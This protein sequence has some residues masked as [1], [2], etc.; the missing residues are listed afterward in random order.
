MEQYLWSH[1]QDNQEDR[2]RRNTIKSMYRR[3]EQR[4]AAAREASSRQALD[5]VPP[6]LT[7]TAVHVS[8]EPELGCL[9]QARPVCVGAV[10]HDALQVGSRSLSVEPAFVAPASLGVSQGEA[11]RGCSGGIMDHE[12]SIGTAIQLPRDFAIGQVYVAYE[13]PKP[14]PEPE[15]EP[16]P[17]E[18]EPEPTPE[19]G[20]EPNNGQTPASEPD[21]TP[22]G[23]GE[24]VPTS[25]AGGVPGN[26]YDGTLR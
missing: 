15:P 4:L 21:N 12:F 13:L 20:P 22:S 6:V 9:V 1:I 2:T 8:E 16:E 25:T 3:Q 10:G 24:P 18:L 14:D 23:T 7:A 5:A 11:D 26:N 17:V 19:P